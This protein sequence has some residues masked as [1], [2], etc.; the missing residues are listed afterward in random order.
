MD[1]PLFLSGTV[2]IG[3]HRDDAVIQSEHRHEEETLELEVYAEYRSCRGAERDQNPVHQVGHDGTDGH[4]QDGRY[5]H[6][7]DAADDPGLRLQD[8]CE[9]EM[10]FFV[11]LQVQG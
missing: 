1:D 6:G 4:H 11:L 7:V 10:N 5:P 9:G 8:Q 2:V 3:Q